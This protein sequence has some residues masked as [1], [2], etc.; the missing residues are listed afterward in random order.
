MYPTKEE[1]L[2]TPVKFR[3]GTIL[4]VKLWKTTAFKNWKLST[5]GDK[6][7]KLTELTKAL[8]KI[9]RIK[10]PTMVP[11]SVY[12]YEPETQSILV[13]IANPSIISTLH[14]LGHHI[15]GKSERKVCRWSIWLF[16][17]CFPLSYKKLKWENHL[18]IK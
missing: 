10:P 5:T 1:I 18:L 11:Y 14:E 4:I 6:L 12:A 3:K 2:E 8:S 17:E 16:K 9:Y 13:D 15:F 7:E